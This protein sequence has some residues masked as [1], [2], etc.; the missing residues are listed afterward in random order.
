M[1][2]TPPH[3]VENPLGDGS[4]LSAISPLS[5]TG[6]SPQSPPMGT[7]EDS[8][9]TCLEAVGDTGVQ[10]DICT[11]W[12]HLACE[13]LTG[14]QYSALGST[15]GS[16]YCCKLCDR[17]SLLAGL[18]DVHRLQRQV[19]RLTETVAKQNTDTMAA[20]RSLTD[21]V[22]KLIQNLPA[23]SG[24]TGSTD[25]SAFIC[26][27]AQELQELESKKDK[28]VILG[29]PESQTPSDSDGELSDDERVFAFARQMG[30]DEGSIDE[31][32]RDGVR[33]RDHTRPR[34][35]KVR[36]NSQGSRSAFLRAFKTISPSRNCWVRPDL[37]YQQRE[38]DRQLRKELDDKN[39]RKYS[40]GRL[41]DQGSNLYCIYKKQVCLRSDLSN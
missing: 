6:I 23:A 31:T 8:C 24:F 10:C 12:L 1:L 21:T 35:L 33:N 27:V 11:R 16:I 29:L 2:R 13:D 18:K 41:V 4:T 25:K 15:P 19:E 39:G 40:N 3:R 14:E 38:R 5:F 34:I 20:I 17:D 7:D 36:F 9:P 22:N 37:T 28:L 32:F 26:E 30:V